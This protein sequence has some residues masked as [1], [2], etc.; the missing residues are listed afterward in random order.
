MYWLNLL[1][2]M[3]TL[4]IT[5]SDLTISDHY[6]YVTFSQKIIVKVT[7]NNTRTHRSQLR[8]NITAKQNK[9]KT[10]IKIKIKTHFT[11][12]TQFTNKKMFVNTEIL[13]KN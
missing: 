11:L 1:H 5:I 8:L 12:Q 3:N 10:Q 6:M 13:T 7:Q 2:N 9:A 4:Y